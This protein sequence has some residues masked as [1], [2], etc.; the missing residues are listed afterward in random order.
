[1][2]HH[3]DHPQDP[4]ADVTDTYIF[5]AAGDDEGP[6]TA[7]IMNT[8]PQ[9]GV[10]G[11]APTALPW[12]PT[13]F[14]ELKL[15]L[16][17]DYV[18]DITWRFTFTPA[19]ANGNQT[20]TVAQLTGA[21]ATSR[22]APGTILVGPGAP[23][24]Q[25]YTTPDGIKIF[26]DKRLDSF[27]NDLGIPLG[28]Q[29][30]LDNPPTTKSGTANPPLPL[31]SYS[32]FF[33]GNNIRSVMVEVPASITGLRRINFWGTTAIVDADHPNGLQVQRCAGPNTA[34]GV[35]RSPI[36]VDGVTVS[37]HDVLNSTE[38]DVDLAGRPA[39][40]E[41]EAG[42]GVWGEI[43]ARVADVV[44]ARR[45]WTDGPNG[46]GTPLAYGAFAADIL[47]PN[48]LPYVPGTTP[49]KW[50]PRLGILNGRGLIDMDGDHFAETIMNQEFSSGLTQTTQITPYFPYLAPPLD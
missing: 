49:I 26:A 25:V 9:D 5:S 47:L 42:T 13:A 16:N 3:L 8:S 15:D 46:R 28:L 7:L 1:M 23:T 4:A 39:K 14:Y 17:R 32:D 41:H 29:A 44:K 20:M 30:A 48:V 18:A 19:D 2:S 33:L 43:Q 40:P 6:R 24:G 45:T 22:T 50:E 27:F 21:D 31:A 11:G 36:V 37:I 34:S 38:P 12:D 35:F 10:P